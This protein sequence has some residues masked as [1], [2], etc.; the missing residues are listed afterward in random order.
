MG[1]HHDHQIFLYLEK[2]IPSDNT[3]AEGIYKK[4]MQWLRHIKLHTIN[5]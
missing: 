5:R 1:N 4:A 3:D 2:N